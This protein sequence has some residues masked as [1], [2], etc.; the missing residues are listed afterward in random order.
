MDSETN[1]DKKLEKACALLAQLKHESL[2][3]TLVN[4]IH[5]THRELCKT[6]STL[7][8]ADL[9]ICTT[10]WFDGTWNHEYCEYLG[11]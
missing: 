1:K 10:C 3:V 9:P 2:S 4:K 8:S 6:T 5:D 11:C 7:G